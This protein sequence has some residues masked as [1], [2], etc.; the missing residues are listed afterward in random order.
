VSIS[1]V[2]HCPT[3]FAK[4]CG[5]RLTDTANR[6]ITQH[7]IYE[8]IT[9]G[10]DEDSYTYDDVIAV[11]KKACAHEFIAAF[12]EGYMTRVGERGARLSGGQVHAS[13]KLL[14]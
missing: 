13:S 5:R 6:L 3:V 12:P 4:A 7:S 8:N 10:L 2:D 1:D 9:Y 11:A 14:I